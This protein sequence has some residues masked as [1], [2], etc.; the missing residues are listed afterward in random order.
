MKQLAYRVWQILWG[1]PQTL[2]GALLF[3]AHLRCQHFG[4]HGAI[5]TVWPRPSS[6]SLGLFIFV[7]DTPF[8]VNSKGAPLPRNEAAQRL[9]VHEYGHT[10]Q[11]LILGPLYLLVIGIPSVLW[12][13]LPRF[14]RRRA[15]Q[16]TSYYRFITERN[17]N[18]LGELVCHE[19][20]P[21]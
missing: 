12:G 7:T 1:F 8:A 14:K 18:Y 21:R 16:N 10:I 17:A 4:F 19:R 3:L 9:L 15:T 2:V 6:V 20:T 11:S 13:Y 5:V